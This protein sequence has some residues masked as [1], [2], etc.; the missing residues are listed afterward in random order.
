M[1]DPSPGLL[2]GARGKVALV[3]MVK[4]RGEAGFSLVF[5]YPFLPCTWHRIGYPLGDSRE[6]RQLAKQDV[7]TASGDGMVRWCVIRCQDRFS[8]EKTVQEGTIQRLE[9]SGKTWR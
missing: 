8:M 2:P 6:P 7:H 1:S 9:E 4:W 3:R 5:L